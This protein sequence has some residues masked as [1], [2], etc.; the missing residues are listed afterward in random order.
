MTSRTLALN[1]ENAPPSRVARTFVDDCIEEHLRGELDSASA[2]MPKYWVTEMQVKVIDR[3]V[4]LHGGYGY[5]H[6]YPIARMFID[7]R[8]Q[9]I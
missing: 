4:Q 5:M 3:C 8:V 2:S 1:Y 9:T 6:E 7:S